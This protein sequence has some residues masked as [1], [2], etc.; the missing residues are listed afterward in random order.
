MN[1]EKTWRRGQ[2]ENM[3]RS[4]A[5]FRRELFVEPTTLIE[6]KMVLPVEIFGEEAVEVACGGTVVRTVPPSGVEGIPRLVTTISRYR[7]IRS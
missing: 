6:V 7:V 2:T 3:S 5:L 4:G 1:S